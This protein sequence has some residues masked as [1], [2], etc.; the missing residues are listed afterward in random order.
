MSKYTKD[1]LIE[2]IKKHNCRLK[3]IPLRILNI[4]IR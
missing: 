2:I 3:I 4:L 1:V